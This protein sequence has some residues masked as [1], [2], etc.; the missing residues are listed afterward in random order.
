MTFSLVGRCARTGMLGIAV[1]S[2]SMAV[3]ARCAY[4]R[5]GVGAVAS[6]NLTD[7]RLGP[8]IL[9]MLTN[10]KTPTDAIETVL[11]EG[12]DREH[13]ALAYRQLAVIDSAGRT[14]THSGGRT[15]PFYAQATGTDVAAAGNLLSNPDVP[16]AMVAAFTEQVEQHLGKRLAAGLAAGLHAGGEGEPVH[17]AAL[18]VVDRVPWPIADLRVDWHDDPISELTRVLHRWLPQVD[19]YLRR[20]LEPWSAP[21]F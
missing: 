12:G 19:D 5:A 18:L 10:R 11:A 2:S 17:S 7:P 15:L 3:G 21:S 9:D 1:A 13:E 4:A 6:Q 16:A 20:A 14:A 8:R